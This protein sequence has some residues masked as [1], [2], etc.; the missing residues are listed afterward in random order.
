M[1]TG[2]I[3]EFIP[4]DG[5]KAGESEAPEELIRRYKSVQ[6]LTLSMDGIP[7]PEELLRL[8]AEHCAEL[9]G[10]GFGA[11]LVPDGAGQLK[12]AA[13][14]GL[15]DDTASALRFKIGYGIAGRAFQDGLP[16]MIGD[17]ALDPEYVQ[18]LPGMKSEIVVPMVSSGSVLGVIRLDS[19]RPN[20]FSHTDLDF[21]LT[22]ASHAGQI[23]SRA[24]LKDELRRK[25]K[26][27]DL[28]IRISHFADRLFELDDIFETVMHRLAE[29]FAIIRGMLVL[30]D[31]NDPSKLQVHAAYNLTDDEI[32]RGIYTVGEGVIGRAVQTGAT[33]SIPDIHKEPSFLNRMRIKRRKDVP[34]SFIA[35]PLKVVGQD[36]GVIAVEKPFESHESLKDDEDL[37]SL[38]ASLISNKV[39]IFRS[40]LAEREQ[41]KEEN[42]TLQQEIKRRYA[43]DSIVCKNRKMLEVLELVKLVADTTTSIMILGESGTG[44][45]MIA[46]AIH[47]ASS[48]RDRPFVSINCAAIPENLLESELFGYKKGAFT[49]AVQDRRG[50]FMQADSGTLFLDEI[51]DMPMHLQVKLL[52]AI[53]EREVEPVG[54]ETRERIDVRFLAAT[55]HD[56]KRLVEEGKFREDLY[57]RLNVV[58]I[59]LPPLR[60]RPDDIPFLV[61][62]FIEKFAEA[63]NRDPIGISP[64]AMRML[65]SYTWPG[66]V[67]ELENV[68]ERAVLLCRGAE[69]E[70]TH[71]PLSLAQ[72]QDAGAYGTFISRWIAGY[73]KSTPETG[74]AWDGIIGMVE[75]ELIQ[76]ALLTNGRNKLKTAE[77][78]GINRN[79]LRYK[80]EQ[81][82]LE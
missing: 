69:I 82:G 46:R 23:L 6:Y 62:R 27:Q 18:I 1:R 26:V 53:Q 78:L 9:T 32:S 42:R 60:E 20:A 19:D 44:K 52:R 4:D 8:T 11:V 81:Y 14:R 25:I 33:I 56:L 66:N 49:G 48:R 79:T 65:Q 64:V 55:N 58:E 41:L 77:Y 12:F 17:V 10:A 54:S 61:G 45:E 2:Q 30:F 29:E 63:H 28:L 5:H 39:R 34:V 36:A 43:I 7:S 40:V 80:M 3:T 21:L 16:R 74:A 31:R 73:L 67:R 57:Y 51:G 47:A 22:V 15:P 70:P 76:Q 24:R 68:I 35:A 75:R 72:S 59:V 71:L 37:I 50:K 38:V 13:W